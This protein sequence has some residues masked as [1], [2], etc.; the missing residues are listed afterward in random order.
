MPPQHEEPRY[1]SVHDRVFAK[2]TDQ[3]FV[4]QR[5]GP[6]PINAAREVSFPIQLLWVL[7]QLRDAPSARPRLTAFQT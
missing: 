7:S 5:Q 4:D 3:E 6:Q 2:F 1:P